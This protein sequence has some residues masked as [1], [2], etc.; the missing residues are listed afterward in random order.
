MMVAAFT[1]DSTFGA[2]Q[3]TLDSLMRAMRAG[4]HVWLTPPNPDA[5]EYGHEVS[6]VPPGDHDVVHHGQHAT[7]PMAAL[8]IAL[9]KYEAKP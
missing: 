2:A 1:A 4:C 3:R 8:V 7:D 9:T 6:I 5:H